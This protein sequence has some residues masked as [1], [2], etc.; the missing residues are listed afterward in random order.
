M[1]YNSILNENFNIILYLQLLFSRVHP[2]TL[3]MEDKQAS[4][5][6]IMP[7]SNEFIGFYMQEFDFIINSAACILCCIL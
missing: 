5:R 2:A 3:D 7:R 6:L 1:I 4:C